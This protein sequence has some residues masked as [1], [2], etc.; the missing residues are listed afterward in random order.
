MQGDDN[1]DSSFLS[2][3]ENDV[4]IGFGTTLK[5]N[6]FYEQLI[7]GGRATIAKSRDTTSNVV[8]N[9]FKSIHN[10]NPTGRFIKKKEDGQYYII[11]EEQALDVIECALNLP[12]PIHEHDVWCKRGNGAK[13]HSGNIFYNNLVEDLKA[14]YNNTKTHKEK[15]RVAQRIFDKLNERKPPGRFIKEINNGDRF[16]MNYEECI[17]KIKQALRDKTKT[18][19]IELVDLEPFSIEDFGHEEM[20]ILQG[21]QEV[22]YFAG[23]RV[24][25]KITKNNKKNINSSAL[26]VYGTHG[27]KYNK[28]FSRQSKGNTR[29][30]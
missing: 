9:I 11:E 14:D 1:Q 8:S 30:K 15:Q 16:I 29:K 18:A 6:V 22:S 17:E 4:M 28:D 21:K 3:N 23:K 26:K 2:L 27:P 13:Y 7:S 10:K 19:N 5:G 24:T 25:L 12:L 20:R